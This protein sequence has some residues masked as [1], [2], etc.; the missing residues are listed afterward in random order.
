MERIPYSLRMKMMIDSIL[1]LKLQT[2]WDKIHYNI[3]K[4]SLYLKKTSSLF[5]P[6]DMIYE[7]VLRANTMVYFKNGKTFT[8][9][10]T[11]KTNPNTYYYCPSYMNSV[12]DLFS[13]N[14]YGYFLDD[15]YESSDSDY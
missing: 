9:L 5:I 4:S 11:M 13:T 8:W 12:Q 14:S 15:I 3:R 2:G 7:H 1:L 10:K 6:Y